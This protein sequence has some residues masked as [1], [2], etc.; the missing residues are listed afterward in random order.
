MTRTLAAIL[1][2]TTAGLT[3]CAT[4]PRAGPAQVVRFVDPGAQAMLGQGTI[5]DPVR[6]R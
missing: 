6:S 4:T 5:V 3:A 2:A 1:L